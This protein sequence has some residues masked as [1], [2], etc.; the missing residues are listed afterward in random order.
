MV[1]LSVVAVL[2]LPERLD[3]ALAETFVGVLEGTLAGLFDGVLEGD[4]GGINLG[5]SRSYH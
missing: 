3:D 4:E 5:G 2:V 1:V